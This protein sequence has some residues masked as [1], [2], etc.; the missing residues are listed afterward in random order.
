MVNSLIKAVHTRLF[1]NPVGFGAAPYA[2]KFTSK[3]PFAPE[4]RE[5]SIAFPPKTPYG[6]NEEAHDRQP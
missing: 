5:I 3:P 6:K 1:Q 2:E 4:Y